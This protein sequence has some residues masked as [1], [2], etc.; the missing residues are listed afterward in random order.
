MKA[1]VEFED[2]NDAQ[3]YTETLYQS[4][5]GMIEICCTGTGIRSISF[6]PD[7]TKQSKGNDLCGKVA[8]QLSEYFAGNRTVFD[9]PLAPLGTLFQQKVWGALRDIPYGETR[10]YKQIAEAIGNPKACRAIGMA[11]N[12]NP[13]GI[14][15]PCHR[16]VGSNGDL[17]GYAA[18]LDKK[19]LLLDLERKQK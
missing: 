1:T 13:I 18:G 14:V 8:E 15:V 17:V 5:L 3:G 7:N 19:Q 6:V 16:V 10:T 2:K 11:N 9:L 12:R 4:G